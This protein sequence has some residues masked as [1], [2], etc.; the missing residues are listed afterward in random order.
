A[1]LAT[2]GPGHHRRE[3]AARWHAL[4]LALLLERTNRAGMRLD[5]SRA[6]RYHRATDYRSQRGACFLHGYDSSSDEFRDLG[7][8][9]VSETSDSVHPIGNPM[10][11][12]THVGFS[13]PDTSHL[14][15]PLEG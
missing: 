4:R 12:S 13:C 6:A 11:H 2:A 9:S 7:D 14:S 8:D 5:I 1:S 15:V 3:P 10:S